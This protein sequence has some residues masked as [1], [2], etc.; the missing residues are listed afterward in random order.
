MK[1]ISDVISKADD[2]FEK[3]KPDALLLYGD[4]NTRLAIIAVK[5]RKIPVFHMEVESLFRSTCT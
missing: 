3:R 5:R 1:T 2:V 4:T